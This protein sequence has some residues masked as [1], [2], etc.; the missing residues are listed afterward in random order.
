VTIAKFCK[1][2]YFLGPENNV[3]ERFYLAAAESNADTIVRIT[4]DCPL[5]DPGVGDKVVSLRKSEAAEYASN[6]WPRSFPKGLDCEAFTMRALSKAY[7]CATEEYD[8]EHVTPYIVRNND[9]VNLPSG[10]FDL[11]RLRLV[12]DTMD[13][14][15]FLKKLF[16]FE[17]KTTEDIVK[18]LKSNP[19][20]KHELTA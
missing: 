3:L 9:R 18:I 1:V 11:A 5:F 4:A 10:R 7:S 15:R 2:R 8:L 12:I 16:E 14:Y 20:L 19:D 17:F 6:V 13:D